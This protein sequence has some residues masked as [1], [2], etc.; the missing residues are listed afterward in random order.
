MSVVRRPEDAFAAMFL[1]ADTACSFAAPATAARPRN[2]ERRIIDR[3]LRVL[4]EITNQPAN[5]HPRLAPWILFGD[6]DR[7]LKQFG[8]RRPAEFAQGRFGDEQV[9]ALD[10]PVEDRCA[11]RNPCRARAREEVAKASSVRTEAG[12]VAIGAHLSARLRG[13]RRADGR[14]T[15]RRSRAEPRRGR[16]PLA[17]PVMR[18]SSPTLAGCATSTSPASEPSSSRSV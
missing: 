14:R 1:S 6:Q 5:R 17:F 2:R 15:P 8:Q 12:R 7:Q 3:G 4:L 9:A 18:I 10:R 16:A 11:R 13:S